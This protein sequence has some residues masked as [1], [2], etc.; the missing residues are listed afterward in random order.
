MS[1]LEQFLFA[2]VGVTMLAASLA[3]SDPHLSF[4][5]VLKNWGTARYS[6][7]SCGSP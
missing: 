1:V 5:D 3:L 6:L 4:A 7:Q 2:V